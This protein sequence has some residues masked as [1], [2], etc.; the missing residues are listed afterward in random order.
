[1]DE[2]GRYWATVGMPS[3]S[4]SSSRM[5]IRGV[6]ISIRLEVVR[7]M[8]MLRNRRLKQRGLGQ[9]G[10][11]VLGAFLVEPLHAAQEDR[12]AVGDGDGRR[13]RG[14]GELRQLDRAADGRR[15]AAEAATADAP[16]GLEWS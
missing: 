4:S 2:S 5:M 16:P 15:G 7:P 10:H 14:Q 12:A 1:M 13:D 11:A 8:P 6:T 9:H 3:G